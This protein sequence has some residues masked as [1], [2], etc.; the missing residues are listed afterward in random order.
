MNGCP[1]SRAPF[2]REV[3][4]LIFLKEKP[5]K[6]N[7]ET[8]P[9]VAEGFP[10]VSLC[11]ESFFILGNGGLNRFHATFFSRTVGLNQ[12]NSHEDA[13]APAIGMNS[14]L[15]AELAQSLAHCADA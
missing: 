11:G 8:R 7:E 14:Q 13:C 1:I 2:A 9:S 12:R 4:T 3:R 15:A 6:E 5:A 10:W